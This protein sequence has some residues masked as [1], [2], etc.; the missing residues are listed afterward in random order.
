MEDPHRMKE[1]KK[2][3]GIPP[4]KCNLRCNVKGKKSSNG[5]WGR[6]RRNHEEKAEIF[7]AVQQGKTNN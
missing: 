2:K 4:K 6:S 5:E 7:E 3:P 1:K